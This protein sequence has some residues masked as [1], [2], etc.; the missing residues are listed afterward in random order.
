MSREVDV[1]VVGSVN[2]DH[3]CRVERLPAPGETVLGGEAWVGSGGKGGNQAVAA[4]LLGARTALVARVGRDDDGRALVRDLAEAWVDTTEVLATG[5]RTGLAFV[6][7]DAAGENSIV[8]APG[9]NELLEPTTTARA[10]RALARP[11]AVLVVQAEIPEAA[12]DAAVGAAGAQGCRAVVNLAPYRPVPAAVL[13]LCDPLVLNES[14]AAGLL[15]RPVR[16]VAS[17]REAVVELVGRCRS[18]VVTLGPHGAVVATGER[19]EH[20]AA[21]RVE[22]VDTTGAGDAFTGALAAAL[23]G[24]ADLLDAVAVGVRAGTFSVGRPGAQASFARAAELGMG[25]FDRPA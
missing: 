13:A 12:F 6:M 21:E 4:S 14:E 18:V 22:V 15:G 1:V 7:V 11:P 2:R 20:V 23:S 9:A 5:A 17:A 3:V 25:P 24:G 19:V 16:G 10:V 8:V